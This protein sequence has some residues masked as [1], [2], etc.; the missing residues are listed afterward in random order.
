MGIGSQSLPRLPNLQTAKPNSVYYDSQYSNFTFT[1][2]PIELVA[3]FFSPVIPNDYCRSSIPLSYLTVETRSLDSASHDVT[4]YSHVDGSW[5]SYESNATLN[6]NI[7]SGGQ[8]VNATDPV[9]KIANVT[10]TQTSIY[11]WVI[12]LEEQYLFGEQS[13]FPQ[14][15]N[16]TFSTAQ[17]SAQQLNYSSGHDI[18]VM[19]NFTMGLGLNNE[20]DANYRGWGDRAP[21]YAYAHHLGSVGSETSAPIQYTLGN[22]QYPAIRYLTG[23]G[24]VSLNPWWS[25][26]YCYGPDLFNV[27]NFH[28]NDI[29]A[30]Q[31][32]G[33]QYESNLKASVA[34]YYQQNPNTV[35]SPEPATPPPAWYNG[36]GPN[37]N[38][39]YQSV[40]QDGVQYIFNSADAY[41]F[42]QPDHT[43]YA[44]GI[45]IPDVSESQAYYSIISLAARQIL[46]A[47]FVTERPNATCDYSFGDPATPITFQK[48]ISSNGNMNTVDVM[49]PGMPFFL[50]SDPNLLRFVMEPL[51]FYQEGNF[52][53]NDYSMHDLG[54][55]F[56]N[57]TGH[58]EGDDEYMPVEESGNMI[59][60][61]LA[62]Y[63]FS[64]DAEFLRAHYPILQQWAQYL[65]EY[66]LV[67]AAQLSTDDFAGQLTNQTNL[68]IKG[69]VGLQAMGQ[70]STVVGNTTAAQNYT[71]YAQ[72]YYDQW[73]DFAIDP[74]ERHTVLAYQFRSSWG[75]LYNVYPDKLLNL[76][77]I[78]QSLYDMQSRWYP[79]VS[80]IYGVPLDS[81]HSYTKSDWELWAAATCEP[82]TRALFVNSVAYWLN[83]TYTDLAFSDLYETIGNGSYPSVPDSVTFIA[84][85]VQ[86]GLFSLLALEEDQPGTVG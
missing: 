22:V 31:A 78:P 9:S 82:S 10:A 13:Q 74:S 51:Y 52:Y 68:A 27:I 15:G 65:I 30:S 36:T 34:A 58:V 83:N 28:F 4:L 25:T 29:S 35:T 1:A 7:Y 38:T 19:F 37:F 69:I 67:P 77:I 42:L 5:S 50:Y 86:G 85:P 57:A 64:N 39:S 12:G 81:R 62:Y 75:I 45:A 41:G 72:Q 14:W 47:Y 26:S 70:I 32:L 18:D 17:Q 43:C 33:E 61:T 84:R 21:I 11:S 20:N 24:L 6:W 79:E 40:N 76:G 2:G 55:H 53:P 23:N 16:F 71:A 60:M 8:P 73:Q 66:S 44:T 49:F 63:K 46:A 59:I 54:T 3:R 56:P 48:E 80:Q